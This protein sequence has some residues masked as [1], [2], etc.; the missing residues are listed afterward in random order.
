VFTAVRIYVSSEF[1]AFTVED[2][3]RFFGKSMCALK[4]LGEVDPHLNG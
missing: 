3:P 1:F 2:S 4:T